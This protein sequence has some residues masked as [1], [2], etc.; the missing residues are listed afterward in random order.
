MTAGSRF[1]SV[2][3]FDEITR[4]TPEKSLLEPV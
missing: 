3:G 2:S 1:R 4:D